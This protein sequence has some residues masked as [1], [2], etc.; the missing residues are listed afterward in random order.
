MAPRS[1]TMMTT[2]KY[3]PKYLFDGFKDKF[4]ST[5]VIRAQSKNEYISLRSRDCFLFLENHEQCKLCITIN[6]FLSGGFREMEVYVTIDAS[7]PNFSLDAFV[8]RADMLNMEIYNG[9]N[10]MFTGQCVIA[11]AETGVNASGSLAHN[12]TLNV[13]GTP[14]MTKTL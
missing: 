7:D 12:L 6:T 11:H 9:R 5:S 3:I 4:T 8:T 14:R 10:L 13:V 2:D 1:K